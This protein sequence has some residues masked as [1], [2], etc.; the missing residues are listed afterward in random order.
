M[1]KN[2]LNIKTLAALLMAG[3]AFTA[4]SNE[5]TIIEEQ[6]VN[7]AEKTY[8]LTIEASKSNVA[9]TRGLSLD[10]KTLNAVWKEGDVVEVYNSNSTIKLGTLTPSSKGGATTVLTGEVSGEGIAV[11]QA[12]QLYLTGKDRDYTGQKGVLLS[13]D[14]PIWS[15]EKRYDYAYAGI[16]E[17]IEITS[18]VDDK[19]IAKKVV[20]G[21]YTDD[22]ATFLNNQAIV[23]FTLVGNDGVTPV[24]VSSFRFECTTTPSIIKANS[25]TDGID[26]KPAH[27]TNVLDAAIAQVSV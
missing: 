12:I 19:L 24:N 8:T 1:K 16:S 26:I 4:C 14:D 15:I 22:P 2:I 21:E 7:P 20:S 3:A 17:R 5:D 13:S 11:G 9:T 23:K 27:D 6:P 18:L 25:S 10:G